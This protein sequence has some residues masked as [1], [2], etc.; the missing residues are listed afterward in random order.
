MNLV[1]RIRP[2]FAHH[3]ALTNFHSDGDNSTATPEKTCFNI[4]NAI[5]P[6]MYTLQ[7]VVKD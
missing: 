6:S 3:G 1:K 4:A 7:I 2:I 5:A